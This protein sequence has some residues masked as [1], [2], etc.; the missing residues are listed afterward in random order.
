MSTGPFQPRST[1][2]IFD[3]I[4]QGL[5]GQ[6]IRDHPEFQRRVAEGMD[7]ETPV[8]LCGWVDDFPK[9]VALASTFAPPLA[10][11][12]P[13][14]M[15][16][17][18]DVLLYKAWKEVLGDYPKY[19][20]QQI[21][22]CFPAGTPVTMADGSFMPIEQIVIGDMVM[23]HLG[24]SRRVRRVIRKPYSGE[25]VTIV[26]EGVEPDSGTWQLSATPDHRLGQ[27]IDLENGNYR[28]NPA[29]DMQVGD[30]LRR[31]G[32]WARATI[33]KIS[34]GFFAENVHCLEVEEDHSFIAN[35]F[36]VHNCTSF[37]SAHAV[38]L[39]QCV[40]IFLLKE[41]TE[42]R[43]ICTEAIY[44]MG[45]E[46][47]G[48]LGGGDGCYGVAVAK[49][50][51]DH[52]AT[53]REKVGP[54]SGTRAKQ[55]GRSGVPAEVK[56][57]MSSFKVGKA[58]LI[59]TLEELDAALANLYPSA[60]GFSQ[61][62]TMTRDVDGVCRQSGRWGHETCFIGRRTRNGR[63][64]YC[65]GQSWGPNVP[66]GPTTDDQPNFSFWMDETPA[67]DILS[68]RDWLTFTSAPDFVKRD[69]PVE[70]KHS[71]MVA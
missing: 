55:W 1:A 39:L 38:D 60:G 18:Q 36:D 56:T 70:F 9:R 7:P 11:A 30:I 64:Q 66:G 54:Y 57:Q 34:R 31:G 71:R 23:T 63:R 51:T 26:A 58:A 6:D 22:D 44:G 65:M 62:F 37:G 40:E 15:G 52:G 12:A 8:H 67:A 10:Q 19:V 13:H 33:T 3:E 25:L 41:A 5:P 17:S 4:R 42:F 45:R 59:T 14:L 16:D 53:T 61:G 2:A 50:L 43:E 20:A 27:V 47:A 21:G 69:V 49:A 48:M 32:G 28:F 24:S 35:G 46:I 29:G 68:Q